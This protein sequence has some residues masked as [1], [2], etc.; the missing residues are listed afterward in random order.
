VS[1]QKRRAFTLVELLVVIGII[2]V[3]ISILLPTLGRAREAANRTQCLSNLH[4]IHLALIEYAQKNHDYVPLGYTY[5]LKQMTYLVW[6]PGYS[7]PQSYPKGAFVCFGFLYK[8]GVVKQG[9]IFYC[10]S[11][12]DTENAFSIPD[13]PWPPGVNP[14]LRVR[15]SYSSR[16]VVDWGNGGDV[17][18]VA[19]P[20]LGKFKNKAVFC[21]VLSEEM[22]LK[23]G[24]KTGANVLYSN[25]AAIWVRKDVF[26]ND[27]KYCQKTFDVGVNDYMLKLDPSTKEPY[28]KELSGLWVDLDYGADMSAKAPAAR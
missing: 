28:G 4:Q 27:L 24:H 12:T 20:K 2:A 17:N 6:D 14:N 16:P 19:L 5:E 25:G 21:D 10:P 3:L 9:Q 18:K 22:R 8:S 13:N 1:K 23:T 15:T 11:R 7:D 26:W